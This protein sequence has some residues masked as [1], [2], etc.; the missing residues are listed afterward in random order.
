MADATP[1][2]AAALEG[3]RQNSEYF[4]LLALDGDVLRERTAT[5][6]GIF[7]THG[8]APRAERELAAAATSRPERLHLL[9]LG[10]RSPAQPSSAY[11]SRHRP[12]ARD[13]GVGSIPDLHLDDRWQ[14]VVE[15]AVELARTPMAATIEH[16]ARLR[17]LGLSDLEIL[18]VSAGR[19]V[20][21]LGQPPDAHPWRAILR[22]LRQIVGLAPS[23]A[24][25][26]R[27]AARTRFLSDRRHCRLAPCERSYGQARASELMVCSVVRRS[28]VGQL[29][30]PRRDGRSP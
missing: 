5:D 21:L 29:A 17:D 30:D 6:M 13:R 14:A 12:P 25:G 11:A 22:G 9:R 19:R 20:L 15:L 3:R 28:S 10:P 16:V 1:T 4:R 26:H 7:Y 2:Q 23:P 8:G 18:D 27:S 24:K